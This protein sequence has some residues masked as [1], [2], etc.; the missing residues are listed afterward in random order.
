MTYYAFA[1]GF[2]GGTIYRLGKWIT[3]KFKIDDNIDAFA[4]YFLPAM[5]SLLI[6]LIFR[7]DFGGITKNYKD[8]NF[9]PVQR[10]LIIYTQYLVEAVFMAIPVITGWVVLVTVLFFG[11]FKLCK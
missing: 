9:T 7:S 10:G 1:L 6:Q 8:N 4:T 2:G 11:S 3:E 5:M